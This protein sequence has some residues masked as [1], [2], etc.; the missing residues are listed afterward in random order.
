MA[1]EMI[2]RATCPE[3]GFASAHVKIKT[4]KEN[5]NPYR[6]CPD[7]GAQY[8]P[9]NKL[10]GENLLKQTRKTAQEASL[11]EKAQEVTQEVE[12]LNQE[13]ESKPEQKFKSVF[14]VMV[15]V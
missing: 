14:G 8:F 12:K 11:V 15:P 3:C 6:H 13:S 1:S 7:C 9:R 2:G 4:D 10:Q 5:A